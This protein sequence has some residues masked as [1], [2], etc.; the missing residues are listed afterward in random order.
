MGKLEPVKVR[1][2]KDY[3]RW[4]WSVE[5]FLGTMDGQDESRIAKTVLDNIEHKCVRRKQEGEK[6]LDVNITTMRSRF[7]HSEDIIGSTINPLMRMNGPETVSQARFNTQDISRGLLSM[8]KVDILEQLSKESL[9][10][11]EK[12]AFAPEHRGQYLLEKQKRM[13]PK[14]E[15]PEG[16]KKGNW[17]RAWWTSLTFLVT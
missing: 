6:D 17:I 5:Q 15:S 3:I 7:E 12:K 13:G 10:M 16:K 4:T 11:L 8:E 14:F 2:A 9:L 1:T